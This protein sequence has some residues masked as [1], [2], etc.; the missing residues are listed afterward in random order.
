MDSLLRANDRGEIVD[1]MWKNSFLK[2]LYNKGLK[3]GLR[4]LIIWANFTSTYTFT[5]VKWV[6]F[7]IFSLTQNL[8]MASCRGYRVSGK[9]KNAKKNVEFTDFSKIETHLKALYVR[10]NGIPEGE[11]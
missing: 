9:L 7:G 2:A 5:L 1:K 6:F 8:K 4:I 11:K 3:G 10:L